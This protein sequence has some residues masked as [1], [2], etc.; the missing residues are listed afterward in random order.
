MTASTVKH[1]AR[2][3]YSID[4]SLCTLVRLNKDT[5]IPLLS[6]QLRTLLLPSCIKTTTRSEPTRLTTSSE[7]YST[8]HNAPKWRLP[9]NHQKTATTLFRNSPHDREIILFR[10][11]NTINNE[12]NFQGRKNV[13]IRF[14]KENQNNQLST[15]TTK[16]YWTTRLRWNSKSV[17]TE[18]H[19]LSLFN[20]Y[21]FYTSTGSN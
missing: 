11:Y 21:H 6:K 20:N 10:T 8:I 3:L 13:T 5:F 2:Q 12:S 18:N 1:N 9:Y 4:Q 15:T 16:P 14:L 19:Y 7:L 17:T